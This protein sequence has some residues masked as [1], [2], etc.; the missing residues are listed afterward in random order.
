MNTSIPN[1]MTKLE[2]SSIGRDVNSLK[3][4]AVIREGLSIGKR[5]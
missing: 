3:P 5:F 2:N 1:L 4:E